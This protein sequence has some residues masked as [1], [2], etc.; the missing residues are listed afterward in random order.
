MTL[1]F[2]LVAATSA[3]LIMDYQVDI[4]GSKDDR[5]VLLEN[6][7]AV[8]QEA[9]SLGIPIIY[10]MVSFREGYPEISDRNIM[11]SGLRAGGRLIAG[12]PGTQIHPTVKPHDQDVV[13]VKKRVNAFFNTELETILKSKGVDTVILMGIATSG[14]ILSTVR[15][16]ADADY[17]IIVIGDCCNDGDQEVHTLLT[18]KILPRQ[19]DVVSTS[20]MLQ[21]LEELKH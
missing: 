16:A 15:W 1:S 21:F 4:V 3:V 5:L 12:T 9:R 11:F 10:V 2:Q 14:V 6:A 18:E 19:S 8:L 20:Q 17:S 13:V 7:R